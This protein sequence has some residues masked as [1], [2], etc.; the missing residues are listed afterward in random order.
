M[1]NFPACKAEMA[2]FVLVYQ[3][4]AFTY[5]WTFIKEKGL[6]FW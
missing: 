6:L 4:W 1:S 3:I 2:Y 5:G